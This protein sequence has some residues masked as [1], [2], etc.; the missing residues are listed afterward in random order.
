MSFQAYL[1]NIEKK[2]GKTPR[3]LIAEAK[4]KGM[5]SPDTK[6]QTI[7]KWL[8]NDYGL[9]RGH[10]M[11]LVYV[12]K[13]GPRISAKHVGSGGT[14]SDESNVLHLDGIDNR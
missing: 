14:H 3:E 8:K 4:Q 1:D 12:I 2:T 13:N 10:A 7:V 11:A 6:S 9:G 5:D